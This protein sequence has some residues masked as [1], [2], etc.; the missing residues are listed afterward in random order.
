MLPDGDRW[1]LEHGR[2]GLPI[3]P[4]F[5]SLDAFASR[6]RGRGIVETFEVCAACVRLR[7]TALASGMAPAG[8]R[9][10]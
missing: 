3:V 8:R 4:P 5:A 1:L 6:L 10:I 2:G 7:G 9:I